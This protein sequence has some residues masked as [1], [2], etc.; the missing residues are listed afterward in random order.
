MDLSTTGFSDGPGVSLAKS[1]KL[2][3]TLCEMKQVKETPLAMTYL[4]HA[5]LRIEIYQKLEWVE[6]DDQA[7]ICYRKEGLPGVVPKLIEDEWQR[8]FLAKAEDEVLFLSYLQREGERIPIR[9]CF[10]C[11]KLMR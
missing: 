2:Y 6:E 7:K 1:K 8:K 3:E 11:G 4:T 10:V 5:K 9:R